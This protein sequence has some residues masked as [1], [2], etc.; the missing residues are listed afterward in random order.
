MA[1]FKPGKLLDRCKVAPPSGSITTA[2]INLPLTFF[3]MHSLPLPPLEF[4][5]FYDFLHPIPEFT[6]SILPRLINSLSSTLIHFYPF[7][8]NLSKPHEPNQP[9]IRCTEGDSV[10]YTVAESDADFYHLFS[11][12]LKDATES[13]PLLP[14]L[15]VS[16]SIIP[17][18]A[19]QVTV[20]PNTG[21]CVGITFQHSICNARAFTHF[22]KTWASISKFEATSLSPEPLPFLDRTMI[23]RTS[24]LQSDT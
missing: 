5:F 17:L 10:S 7:S 16:G 2:F 14:Q 9:M 21:I 20:F 8:G 24:A 6:H 19:I 11:N 3:D 18:L 15:P 23:R 1:P 13:H 4:L 12:N 22:M